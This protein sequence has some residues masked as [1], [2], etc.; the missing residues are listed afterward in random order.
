VPRANTSLQKILD[1]AGR[2]F[3]VQ[4]YHLTS[5]DD[6]AKS[7]EVA[8]G[9]LYYNFATK[10]ALFKAVVADGMEYMMT[11]V[12]AVTE[13]SGSALGMVEKII[14]L[15][16]DIFADH[17]HIVKIMFNEISGGLDAE[18]QVYL[19]D[20]RQRY[21]SFFAGLLELGVREG[22]VKGRGGPLLASVL[23]DL[24]Y[25]VTNYLVDHPD[26]MD[27]DSTYCFLEELL[28][29]GVLKRSEV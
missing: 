4:G 21:T 24:I 28:F 16:I 23:I 8:K 6:I 19:T 1:A 22:V 17:P 2:E 25:S 29:D 27:G 12:N 26:E 14:R 11:S 3:S 18:I 20:L 13:Q 7:A 5:M 9:T 10:A 15:H